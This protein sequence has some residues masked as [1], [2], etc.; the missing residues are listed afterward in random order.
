MLDGLVLRLKKQNYILE[1]GEDLVKIVS[2]NGFDP[3]MGA[4]PMQRYIQN[5]VEKIISDKIIRGEIKQEIPFKIT[6]EEISGEAQN[7]TRKINA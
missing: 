2:E 7:Q 6:A 1:V 5:K 4:R 3:T